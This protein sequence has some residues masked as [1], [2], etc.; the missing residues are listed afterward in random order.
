LITNLLL[1][2][3]TPQ[4]S[5]LGSF[6]EIDPDDLKKRFDP[7]ITSMIQAKVIKMGL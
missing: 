3:K 7:C 5:P 6:R 2:L 1:D 4:R